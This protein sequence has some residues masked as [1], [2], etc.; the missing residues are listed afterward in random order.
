[1]GTNSDRA[2]NSTHARL[3]RLLGLL[4]SRPDWSGPELAERLEVSTRTIRNDIARLRELGY[5][6]DAVPGVAG[7]YRLAAGSHM[8]PLLLDD[9]EVVAVAVGLRTAASTSIEGIEETSLRAFAK[10]DQLLPSRLRKRVGALQSHV[11]PLQWHAP[12]ATV[13]PEALAVFSMACRDREQVRFDYADKG[14]TETRRLVEP[15][16]LV[17]AGQRWYLVAWDVRREDWRTFRV[18]RASRPKLAGVRSKDRTL[19][20]A[21]A[22]SFV[23]QSIAGPEPRIP[24]VVYFHAPLSEVEPNIPA[25]AGLLDVVDDN[26]CRFRTLTT[27]I[28]WLALQ[29]ARLGVEFTVQEPAALVDVLR[30]ISNRIDASL[31]R[32]AS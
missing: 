12:D 3:L 6:V 20:A 16:R 24:A 17:P 11:E 31:A 14:G 4:Q 9:E 32:S 19:P 10:L 22:P 26:T 27:D 30:S 15:Y 13:D 25:S 21:D 1:M 2:P 18:D 23:R 28:E 29:I 7:G 8:P 5:P